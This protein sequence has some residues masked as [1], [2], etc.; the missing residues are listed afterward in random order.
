MCLLTCSPDSCDF[1]RV[2]SL[3]ID[4][5]PTFG[6]KIKA[7]IKRNAICRTRFCLLFILETQTRHN[8]T[9]NRRESAAYGLELRTFPRT[10]WQSFTCE[11]ETEVTLSR[12]KQHVNKQTRKTKRRRSNVRI[13]R[14]LVSRAISN[15]HKQLKK[16]Y[17][18]DMFSFA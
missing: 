13:N 8:P 16:H 15:W 14:R 3:Y 12:I 10:R 6:R 11:E 1:I 4:Q 17:L 9:L 7:T 18:S 5:S 2:F